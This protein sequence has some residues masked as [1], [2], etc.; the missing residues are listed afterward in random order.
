MYM[1]MY[2][3]MWVTIMVLVFS[4]LQSQK[5]TVPA[6]IT[7]TSQPTQQPPTLID[8]LYTVPDDIQVGREQR[9]PEGNEGEREA[10]ERLRKELMKYRRTAQV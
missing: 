9:K 2:Y 6:T 7:T 3:T 8:R 5:E 4:A 1:C 10:H